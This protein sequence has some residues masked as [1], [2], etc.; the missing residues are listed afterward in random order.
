M[1]RGEITRDGFGLLAAL[2]IDDGKMGTRPCQG[3]TNA[4]PQP[5]IAAGD[6]RNLPCEIHASLLKKIAEP[7]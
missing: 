7:S 5:A 1:F 4:L 6:Q 2:C 3:M